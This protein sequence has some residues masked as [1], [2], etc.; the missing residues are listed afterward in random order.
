M[1]TYALQLEFITQALPQHSPA[2]CQQV[3]Y[4]VAK[5]DIRK[6]IF[7]LLQPSN[8]PAH[9]LQQLE[10][11]PSLEHL[12]EVLLQYCPN[13]AY[14]TIVHQAVKGQPFELEKRLLERLQ[15]FKRAPRKTVLL[16]IWKAVQGEDTLLLAYLEGLKY[17]SHE[18]SQIW[19]EI[20]HCLLHKQE[21]IVKMALELLARMPQGVERSLPYITTLLRQPQWQFKALKALQQARNLPSSTVQSLVSPILSRYRKE[22]NKKNNLWPEFR[23]IQ[24]IA[25]NNQVHLTLPD[26]D[27]GIF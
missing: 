11:T 4:E 24:S 27:L 8:E 5:K 10:T 13:K 16:Q 2:T 12:E 20:N 26:I 15:T 1:D 25:S 3:F 9:S 14:Q 7:Y 23:L 18:L 22:S 19:A 17:F 21:D 6:A